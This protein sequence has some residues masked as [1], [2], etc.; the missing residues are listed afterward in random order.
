MG[1]PQNKILVFVIDEHS[2][3]LTKESL[4]KLISEFIDKVLED[5]N[6]EVVVANGPTLN[7]CA[8]LTDQ[9]TGRDI[10]SWEIIYFH[11]NK[12]PP[13]LLAQENKVKLIALLP[14]FEG[15]S[16]EAIFKILSDADTFNKFH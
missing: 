9:I 13:V 6:V 14:K 5:R 10:A 3:T 8:Y 16:A 7:I 11:G 12:Y 1:Q 2:R 4:H 15:T